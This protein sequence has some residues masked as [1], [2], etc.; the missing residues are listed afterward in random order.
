MW[1]KRYGRR[2]LSESRNGTLAGKGLKRMPSFG[3]NGCHR[4]VALGDFLDNLRT[5]SRLFSEATLLANR[6]Q[7]G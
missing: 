5:F 2:N 1:K 7:A 3:L 6:R 4:E